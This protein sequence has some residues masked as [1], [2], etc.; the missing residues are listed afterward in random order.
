[1]DLINR[2]TDISKITRITF[3]NDINGLRAISV[4]AVVFYH[5]ELELFKGGW[6]GVDI[7]FVISGYLISNIIISEL[8]E[9]TFSFKNFYRRRVKRILPVFYFI[10]ILTSL[11]AVFSFNYEKLVEYSK[12]LIAAISFVS[13][14]Y[15]SNL[16]FYTY[17][18]IKYSFLVHSWS[19]AIEEQFYLLFPVVL[20]FIYKKL[21]SRAFIFLSLIGFISF[22]LN[23]LHGGQDKFYF[24]QYRMW[25]FIAGCI[26]MIISHN[27][28]LKSTRTKGIG[29]FLILFSVIYFNDDWILDIEP[30]IIAILG[31]GLFLLD[32]NENSRINFLLN[33]KSISKIGISSYS[34]YLLHQPLFALIRIFKDSFNRGGLTML[35]K[36][37]SI[38]LLIFISNLFYEK[39]EMVY[40]KETSTKSIYTFLS[41]NISVISVF[42]FLVLI[43]N[44]FYSRY[45]SSDYNT[46]NGGL[47][48][49][50]E[51][52][53][54]G[55]LSSDPKFI[56]VGD[57]HAEHYSK[58]LNE[59]GQQY[60]FS[61]YKYTRGNCLSL[62]NYT[63][64]YK[65]G[66]EDYDLCVN[67]FKQA[68]SKAE[69]FNIPIVYGNFWVYDITNNSINEISSWNN[70]SKPFDLIR[71][72]LKLSINE[73]NVP[74]IYV[75]G[76]TI[77]SSNI[78]FSKPIKCSNDDGTQIINIFKFKF[79]DKFNLCLNYNQQQNI[80]INLSIRNSIENYENIIFLDPV[81]IYCE[82]RSCVDF[83]N[84]NYIYLDSHLSYEG[85]KLLTQKLINE[86]NLE[87]YNSR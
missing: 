28:L 31:T 27:L 6:L 65:F 32:K 49:M 79:I 84:N 39:I 51:I 40:I 75:I 47:G 36:T 55:N 30:K 29:I 81:E 70:R 63:N 60:K 45:D 44:G 71:D 22:S 23:I 33:L 43:S 61:F 58:S 5:A 64:T 8:N 74:N 12:S 1:M 19:L 73:Y 14:I 80:G 83:L 13:N 10:C 86:L 34:M 78:P 46:E 54:L 52:V 53:Q 62:I 66:L 69:E 50:N 41:K 85:S 37:I 4:L 48:N 3:R 7:F 35:D 2:L 24:L 59:Y 25:E 16:D 18:P 68:L 17:D 56:L 20:F 11:L 26:V 57:S 76:K 15:F 38:L 82:L 87:N 67:L 21:Q 77:G 9:G 42:I 72:E